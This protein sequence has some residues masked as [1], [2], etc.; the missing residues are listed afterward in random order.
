MRVGLIAVFVV[1]ILAG[2]STAGP[3]GDVATYDTLKVARTACEAK[4]E[5]MVL[6]KEG[7]PQRASAYECKRKP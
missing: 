4:G 7:D 6:T 3:N 1:G 2:C 5:A